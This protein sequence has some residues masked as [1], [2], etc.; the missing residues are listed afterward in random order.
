MNYQ[1]GGLSWLDSIY[2][3]HYLSTYP[4]SIQFRDLL[5]IYLT[6]IPIKSFEHNSIKDLPFI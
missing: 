4:I 3:F 5:L 2:R 1:R 6:C